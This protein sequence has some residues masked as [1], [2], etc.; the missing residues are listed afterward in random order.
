MCGFV[1]IIDR[2]RNF[3]YENEI[4]Q[5][6]SMIRH[7]GPDESSLYMQK[8]Q[9][10][11]LGFNRLAMID[12][13]GSTQPY[14]DDSAKTIV[15][16]NGEIYNFL[17]LKSIL[18]KTG[19]VFKSNGEVE[20][21]S[22]LYNKF[23]INF[24]TMLDGMFAICII[25][26]VR[27]KVYLARDRFGMKPLYYC[28]VDKKL[29]FFSELKALPK[30]ISK[31][32]DAKSLSLY[33]FL[34][35]IPAPY[36]IY[37]NV[38]KVKAG[39]WICFDSNLKVVRTQFYSYQ[40]NYSY[41]KLSYEKLQNI[42]EEDIL[43][44]Y[45]SS[46]V[47]IGLFFSG[48]IDS[49]IIASSIPKHS[50]FSIG[51]REGDQEEMVTMDNVARRLQLP[52]QKVILSNQVLSLLN[53]AV[54]SLDEPFYSSISISTYALSQ[55]SA[56]KVK[57]IMTG[58][59][60][61][62]LILGYQYLRKAMLSK[63]V[64]STYISEIGWLKYDTAQEWLLD[65]SFCYD[66]L[67]HFMFADCKIA[68]DQLETLRRCELFK[69]LPDYHMMR[70]DKLTMAAGIEAR[71]PYLRNSYANYM[72]SINPAELMN[73]D[74]PKYILKKSFQVRLPQELLFSKKKPFYAPTKQWIEGE[75]KNDIIRLF[76]EDDLIQKLQLN[77]RKV[78]N[79][80]SNYKGTYSDVSN[81]WGI[82]MLLK[83]G[84]IHIK[85]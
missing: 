42:L 66:E 23:G 41:I 1:G 25:D 39:E 46:D 3:D 59:G 20:V 5:M 22:K 62:E 21:L 74:D 38:Y 67:K 54:Y 9:G 57:G 40:N 76:H 29:C 68:G 60:S 27:K 35:F 50:S 56:K 4:K 24:L 81:L 44:T 82:Y 80:I 16:F 72:L 34:R 31:E 51:Y 37:K 53:K 36:T 61:D 15:L 73:A 12:L 6:L 64:Y 52:V 63:D 65:D 26:H 77:K 83:W 7:R 30:Y 58:D 84:E 17:E 8:E 43:T 85:P 19:E 11:Y 79:L 10:I 47:P 18:G 55:E 69:R 49:G 71:I 70:V 45:R 2:T 78:I 33:F 48:G 32:I 13:I 14:I 28:I 75:L